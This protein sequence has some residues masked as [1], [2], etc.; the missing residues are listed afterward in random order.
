MKFNKNSLKNDL[1]GQISAELILLMSGIIIIVIVAMNLYQ[2]YLVDVS[3][4]LKNNE[5][6]TLI[7]KIDSINQYYKK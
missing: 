5:V 1:N 2:Q 3:N 6:N 7:E 4:E